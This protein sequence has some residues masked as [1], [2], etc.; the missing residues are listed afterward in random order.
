VV[1]YRS[2]SWLIPS[3]LG[4]LVYALQIHTLGPVSDRHGPA[5]TGP[6]AHPV[7]V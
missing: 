6:E 4:W 5:V 2:V 1:V 7:P 3:V